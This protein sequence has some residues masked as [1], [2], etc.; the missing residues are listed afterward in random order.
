MPNS[1]ALVSDK[2]IPA[3]KEAAKAG[4]DVDAALDQLANLVEL[5][6]KPSDRLHFKSI[7]TQI[8]VSVVTGNPVIVGWNTCGE[9][10]QHLSGCR[11]SEPKMP[12]YIDKWVKEFETLSA[13]TAATTAVGSTQNSEVPF[14]PE[15]TSDLAKK[16]ISP[17]RIVP[18]EEEESGLSP[19][20]GC[21]NPVDPTMAD[22]QDDGS[23]MCFTCQESS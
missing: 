18:E 3:L 11:C 20:E 13:G 19:C 16:S 10:L 5:A 8:G 7:K 6:G 1:P 12:E 21:G 15:P 9:C 17:E 23:L 22:V 4:V 14:S 2:I